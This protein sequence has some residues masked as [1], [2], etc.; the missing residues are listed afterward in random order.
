MIINVK[1]NILAI[2]MSNLKI[3]SLLVKLIFSDY[4]ASNSESN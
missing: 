4:S 2:N 1:I 3:K